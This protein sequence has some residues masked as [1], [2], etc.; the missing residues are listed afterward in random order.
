MAVLDAGGVLD[1]SWRLSCSFYVEGGEAAGGAELLDASLECVCGSVWGERTD[2]R[3]RGA[4]ARLLCEVSGGKRQAVSA[5]SGP[6]SPQ[7]RMRSSDRR[8]CEGRCDRSRPLSSDGR[9]RSAVVEREVEGDC[10][11]CGDSGSRLLAWLDY[12]RRRVGG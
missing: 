10:C 3:S 5:I 9:S 4:D 1:S 6:D 7:E 11:E 8:L 2:R 12:L